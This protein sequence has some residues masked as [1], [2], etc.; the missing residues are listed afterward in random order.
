MDH[1]FHFICKQ[2][3]KRFIW[4][5]GII[6]A[7][8]MVVQHLE[9]P[10]GSDLSSLLSSKVLFIRENS[11]PPGEPTSSSTTSS[12]NATYTN[13]VHETRKVTQASTLTK[14]DSEH[15]SSQFEGNV[16]RSNDSSSLTE[17][18]AVTNKTFDVSAMSVLPI[19]TMNEVLQKRHSLPRSNVCL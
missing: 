3:S 18:S 14:V 12:L 11:S 2:E 10:Y 13:E 8:L 15:N 4:I 19:S 6:F 1:E 16:T 7:V 9:L 5:L 17:L